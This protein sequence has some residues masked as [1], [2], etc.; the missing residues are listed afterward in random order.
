MRFAASPSSPSVE[1]VW[2][3][4]RSFFITGSAVEIT[5]STWNNAIP[6]TTPRPWGRKMNAIVSPITVIA[7]SRVAELTAILRFSGWSSAVMASTDRCTRTALSKPSPRPMPKNTPTIGWPR[8]AAASVTR[9]AKITQMANRRNGRK[10]TDGNTNGASCAGVVTAS[11]QSRGHKGCP[12]DSVRGAPSVSEGAGR[13]GIT[14]G[15]A[16]FVGRFS[17]PIGGETEGPGAGN[18]RG[19]FGFCLHRTT[20]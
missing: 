16:P 1:L 2:P 10:A 19:Y 14:Q 17:V 9:P 3:P 15:A 6:N 13:A 5:S 11:P 20:W 4:A 8:N 12:N 7:N 18:P